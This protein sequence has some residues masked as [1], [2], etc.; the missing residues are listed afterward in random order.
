MVARMR[1]ECRRS[2]TREQLAVPLFMLTAMKNLASLYVQDG[3]WDTMPLS[4]LTRYDGG[5]KLS[6]GIGGGGT[7][8]ILDTRKP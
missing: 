1:E 5:S 4:K 6:R 8:T 3:P 7:R 2:H